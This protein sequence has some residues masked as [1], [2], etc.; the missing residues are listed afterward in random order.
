MPLTIKGGHYISNKCENNKSSKFPKYKHTKF[1]TEDKAKIISNKVNARHE[2]NSHTTQKEII[3]D[4]EVDS[5]KVAMLK[6]PNWKKD[7]VPME[8]WSILSDH[9]KYVTYGES[10]AFQKLSIDSMNYRQSRDL[11]K[12]LNNEQIIKTSL[13]FCKSPENLKADYL[14]M[15]KGVYMD[16]ISTDR[17]NEDTNL[18]TTY[19]GQVDMARD[20]EV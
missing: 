11:Y 17:F 10:E 20:T 18:S 4:F 1:F 6:E 9:V 7:L 5:Y 3:K 13:N 14:D 8:E 19:L 12:R 2:I 16:V 15:Y